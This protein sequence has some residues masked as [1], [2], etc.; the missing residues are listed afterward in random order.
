[1]QHSIIVKICKKIFQFIEKNYRLSLTR[2]AI[3]NISNIIKNFFSGSLIYKFFI[4]NNY[5]SSKFLQSSVIGRSEAL[6]QKLL[7][8]LNLLYRKGIGGSFILKFEEDFKRA[9]AGFYSLIIIGAVLTYNLLSFINARV[10]VLQLYISV[11]VVFLVINFYFINTNNLYKNSL[12]KK[13][14]DGIFR[15]AAKE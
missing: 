10:Y 12:I 3:I 15:D 4:D 5:N 9:R 6:L 14:V 2:K 11:I 7:S 8:L 13:I 1:M